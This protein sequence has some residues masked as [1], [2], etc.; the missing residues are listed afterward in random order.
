MRLG[1]RKKESKTCHHFKIERVNVK[2]SLFLE[3]RE[4]GKR[5]D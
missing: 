3:G 1:K 5:G 4:E 2:K